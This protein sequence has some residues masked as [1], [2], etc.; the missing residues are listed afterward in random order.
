MRR[1]DFAT[2]FWF[3]VPLKVLVLSVTVFAFLSL[4]PALLEGDA[5]DVKRAI[6]GFTIVAFFVSIAS[7]FAVAINDSFVEI[8]DRSVII[9]FEAFFNMQFPLRDV[10]AARLIDPRPGWRYRFGLSTNFTDRIACSH[11][12]QFIEIELARPWRTRLWPRRIDV[13]RVW[14][15]VTDAPGLLATLETH[16]EARGRAY[17]TARQAA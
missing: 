10:V 4:I 5:Q 9:R 7:T 11:G 17:T 2:A 16:V 15:A 12:G 3:R 1:F 14:V 8:D 13:T 6:F